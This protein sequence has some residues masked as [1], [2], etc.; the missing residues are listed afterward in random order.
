MSYS[1]NT[2]SKLQR[3]QQCI[4]VVYTGIDLL[5]VDPHT[6]YSNPVVNTLDVS[7]FPTAE[8]IAQ[9]HVNTLDTLPLNLLDPSVAIGFYFENRKDFDSF[10]VLIS[11]RN[12]RNREV[13]RAVL[14]DV[15][16]APPTCPDSSMLMFG[17]GGGGGGAAGGGGAGE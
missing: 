9:V 10:S 16:H 3:T 7:E 12:K 8:H 14:F 6:T 4:V 11:D 1:N 17:G 5:G 15:K 13:D 2:Y